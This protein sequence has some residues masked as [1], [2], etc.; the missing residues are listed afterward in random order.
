MNRAMIRATVGA[1]ALS[2]LVS[3]H[4]DETVRLSEPV[5]V[6]ATHE[7]FGAALPSE[8]AAQSLASVVENA[9]EFLQKDVALNTRIAKV[10]QK[11]GCF[12]VATDGA[13]SAR[14][15]F[16]DYGFFIPTDAG[17]K[18]VELVGTFDRKALDPKRAAHYAKDL[19]ETPSSEPPAFEYVIVA[20]AVRI[21]R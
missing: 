3:V 1:F 10:C 5:E 7:T 15:T 16:K 17:G 11:K 18:D 8:L 9:D 6:T 14:V 13:I 12:F 2:A 19:G 21:P 20:S 4:A